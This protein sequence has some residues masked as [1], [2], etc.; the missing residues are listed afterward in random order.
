MLCFVF[1]LLIRGAERS[2]LPDHFIIDYPTLGCRDLGRGLPKMGASGNFTEVVGVHCKD[3]VAV[4]LRN[5][6][7][8]LQ[9]LGKGFMDF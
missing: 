2:L 6:A 7:S 5:F 8:S 9:D 4:F 3:Y 1:F